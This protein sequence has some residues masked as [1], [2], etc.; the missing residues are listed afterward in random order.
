MS[1][2]SNPTVATVAS[3][4]ARIRATSSGL[5]SAAQS[6]CGRSGHAARSK[7]GSPIWRH[8]A[9]V[10]AHHLSRKLQGYDA[11]LM[12]APWPMLSRWSSKARRPG[13]A[14]QLVGECDRQHA[15]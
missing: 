7:R 8:E 1:N 6:C 14:G 11:R 12:P 5:I 13:Y 10:G 4:L 9:C 15:R 2:K 3:I